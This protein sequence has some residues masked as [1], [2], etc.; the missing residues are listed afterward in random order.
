MDSKS[1]WVVQAETGV[2]I[3]LKVTVESVQML[4]QISIE[5]A[6]RSPVIVES[7]SNTHWM[8]S[9]PQVWTPAIMQ[10]LIFMSKE[11]KEENLILVVAI[12][13]LVWLAA[14]GNAQGLSQQLRLKWLQMKEK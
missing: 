7:H 9:N 1:S 2:D 14:F 4:L 10:E 3:I 11:S 6:Q 13:S 12:F 5:E 8:H